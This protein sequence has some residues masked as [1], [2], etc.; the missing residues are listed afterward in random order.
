MKNVSKE[1]IVRVESEPGD[2][3]HYSYYVLKDGCNMYFIPTKIHNFQYP[4]FID[5]FKILHHRRTTSA[6]EVQEIADRFRSNP[7][8][9][10]ECIRT[11]HELEKKGESK[12]V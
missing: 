3:T 11:I 9:V 6:D 4:K 7:C 12:K 5:Q 10:L 1:K 2:G 8:T